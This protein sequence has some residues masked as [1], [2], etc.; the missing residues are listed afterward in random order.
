MP[1]SANGT[2]RQLADE[3]VGRRQPI[4]APTEMLEFF[5]IKIIMY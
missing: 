1:Y 4:Q 2:I 5:F 3:R